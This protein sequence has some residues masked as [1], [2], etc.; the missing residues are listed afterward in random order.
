MSLIQQ[1]S[2]T[3]WSLAGGFDVAEMNNGSPTL[4]HSK[5]QF[6]PITVSCVKYRNRFEKSVLTDFREDN[7]CTRP[8][9]HTHA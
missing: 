6:I 5:P 2:L 1:H 4:Q 9:R 7:V 3:S 8:V